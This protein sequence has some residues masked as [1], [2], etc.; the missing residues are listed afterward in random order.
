MEGSNNKSYSIKPEERCLLLGSLASPCFVF[1]FR[2]SKRFFY[3][4]I[5]QLSTKCYSTSSCLWQLVSCVQ[6]T[7]IN[8]FCAFSSIEPRASGPDRVSRPPL[9][10][11]KGE[12]LLDSMLAGWNSFVKY[13]C[14]FKCKR[15]RNFSSIDLIFVDFTGV[16]LNRLISVT[17]DFAC[18]RLQ[19]R[20]T[21]SMD[22]YVI[23]KLV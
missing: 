5:L 4:R 22:Y 9:T 20:K 21:T 19:N 6:E 7:I 13:L 11:D 18:D 12:E 8:D 1:L 16:E 3:G 15:K 10:D 17:S 23:I 2:V 14:R